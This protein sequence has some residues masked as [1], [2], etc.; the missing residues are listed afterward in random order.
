MCVILCIVYYLHKHK[1]HVQHPYRIHSQL[2]VSSQQSLSSDFACSDL[3]EN[4]DVY[5]VYLFDQV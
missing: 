3:Y 1:V 5:F 4:G 2:Q